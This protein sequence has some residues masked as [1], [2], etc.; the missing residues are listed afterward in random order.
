[1]A[2][3]LAPGHTVA[4]KSDVSF[5]H[6]AIF[7]RNLDT[8]VQF[9]SALFHFDTLP[10]PRLELRYQWFRIGNGLAL[11]MV[12]GLK[13]TVGLPF[14][15]HFCFSVRSITDFSALLDR[16]GIGYYSGPDRKKGFRV[17]DDGVTQLFFQDP[18]K[19]WIE[20]NDAKH[21]AFTGLPFGNESIAAA[22][23]PFAQMLELSRPNIH[24]AALGVITGKWNFLDPQRPF[25]KGTVVRTPMYDGRFYRV[26]VTGGRLQVPIADGKMKEDNYREL[27]LEGYDNGRQQFVSTSIN[28]HI[29]SDIEMQ[30]GTY[31]SVRRTFTYVWESELLRGQKVMNKRVLKILEGGRYTEEYFEE[32][33]GQFVRIRELDYTKVE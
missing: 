22:Q 30:M 12:E 32:K 9:Y 15:D 11:H 6:V 7:V 31:D 18:D 26:E 28:N 17:R 16:R 24:H 27:E 13:D 3:F 29:G 1:M 19:Y 20:V 33:N 23:D 10:H 5:D 8:S 2:F 14:F 4:Q 21:P 25:I